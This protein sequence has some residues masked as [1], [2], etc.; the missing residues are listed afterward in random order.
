MSINNHYIN[1]SP[2]VHKKRVTQQMSKYTNEMTLEDLGLEGEELVTE[3]KRRKDR[4]AIVKLNKKLIKQAQNELAGVRAP[5]Q[6]KASRPPP[7]PLTEYEQKDR[8]EEQ[9]EEERVRIQNDPKYD[10]SSS[11][12]WEYQPRERREMA[13]GVWRLRNIPPFLRVREE[14][15]EEAAR[16]QKA[17]RDAHLTQ[18]NEDARVE[19]EMMYPKRKWDDPLWKLLGY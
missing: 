12:D 16:Q 3:K 10:S 18:L 17:E 9:L 15:A 4:A 2:R 19:A 7:A 11:A 8:Y 6:Q 14:A 1:P 13:L 5:S